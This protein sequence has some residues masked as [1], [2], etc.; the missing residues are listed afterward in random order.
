SFVSAF[1]KHGAIDRDTW[2]RLLTAPLAPGQPRRSVLMRYQ[3]MCEL[4][5]AFD[6]HELAIAAIERLNE[7]GFLDITW[8]DMCPL[9]AKIAEQ[10]SFVRLRQ[11]LGDRAARVLAAFRSVTA[12]T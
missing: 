7:L 5:L 12:S 1:D 9:M 10:P 11:V 8:L 3:I 2:Q 4:A 6:A